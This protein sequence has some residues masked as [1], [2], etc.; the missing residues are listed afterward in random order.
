MDRIMNKEDSWIRSYTGGKVYF[1]EPE[2]S[3]INFLDICHALSLL[4]RFNGATD[5][6]YSIAQHS[7]LVA[8][9]VYK[10]TKCKNLAYVGLLHDASEAFISDIPSPF[11]AH[12]PGFKEVEIKMEEWLSKEFRFEY[13]FDP[14][15]KKHDLKALST[16]MRDLMFIPDNQNLPEP[17][18]NIISPLSWQESRLL[19]AAKFDEYKPRGF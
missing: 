14:I 6:F 9:E 18:E 8:D 1:F 3:T 7:V 5:F 11:K 13:P 16:E 4:C 10:E 12:F 15:I 17:Y 19:F 2:K